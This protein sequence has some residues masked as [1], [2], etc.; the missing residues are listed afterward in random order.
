LQTPPVPWR[1]GCPRNKQKNIGSNRNKPKKDLF[2]LCFGLFHETKNKKFWFVSVLS[3]FLTYFK[4][5]QTELFGNKPKQPK[6]FS[7]I[8]KYAQYQTVSVGLLFISVQSQHGNSL[9]LCRSETTETNCFE[10]NQNKK[11]NKPPKIF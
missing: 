3:V 11:Q 2:W 4:P 1:L 7:K 5:K 10:T 8:P 6:I 9:F